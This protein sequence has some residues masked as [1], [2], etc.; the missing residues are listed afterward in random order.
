M[1]WVRPQLAKQ[2][3]QER[4]SVLLDRPCG[5]PVYDHQCQIA[6]ARWFYTFGQAAH[7]VFIQGAPQIRTLQVY[8]AVRRLTLQRMNCGW[9]EAGQPLER[10]EQLPHVER[11]VQMPTTTRGTSPTG[12]RS[13]IRSATAPFTAA[14]T[15]TL[16]ID[17]RF[18]MSTPASRC[19]SNATCGIIRCG[20]AF[21]PLTV[22]VALTACLYVA[23][24]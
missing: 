12:G 16:S 20:S 9:I 4:R 2:R 6:P 10:L 23:T 3:L 22:R 21:L 17:C 15:N 7:R 8:L 14:S 24:K 1:R 19:D 11:Q 5:Q 13:T 18:S